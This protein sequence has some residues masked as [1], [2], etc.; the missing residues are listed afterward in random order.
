MCIFRAFLPNTTT[1]EQIAHT[2]HGTQEAKANVKASLLATFT[3]SSFSPGSVAVIRT[4]YRYRF[5][6]AQHPT[7]THTHTVSAKHKHSHS[8][9]KLA[10]IL[11]LAKTSSPNA[12]IEITVIRCIL[13]GRLSGWVCD[14]ASSLGLGF[15]G[16]P[17]APLRFSPFGMFQGRSE[18]TTLPAQIN[19]T[20][21]SHEWPDWGAP[22]GASQLKL[23]V[24]VVGYARGFDRTVETR[25]GRK[26]LTGDRKWLFSK[27][28]LQIKC[29]IIRKWFYNTVS[30]YYKNSIRKLFW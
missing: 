9:N 11:R 28:Q 23:E 15:L 13:A 19:Q 30:V 24:F 18:A 26:I 22:N 3:D 6:I 4:F 5:A 29:I 7:H 16:P 1:C 27:K 14:D 21:G 2:P 8:H 25:A 17:L 12:L 10:T 20:K